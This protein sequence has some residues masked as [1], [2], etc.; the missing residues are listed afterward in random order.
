MSLDTTNRRTEAERLLLHHWKH[1]QFRTGQWEIIEAI[2][3]GEDVL[4]ILPT[5]GGKSI[6]YQLPALLQEGLTL[7]V[8]PLI[9][10]MQDQVAGLRARKISAA[11]IN[12]TLSA[13]EVDQRWTDAEFGRYRL[14]YV[15]PERLQSEVFQARA[16]R[17]PVKQIVVDEAHCISEWGR[18]FRPAY[19]EIAGVRALL[20]GPPVAAFTATAT[21]LVR[22]DIVEQLAL[23]APV[24]VA[25]GFD[26]PNITWSIFRTPSKQQKVLEIIGNVRGSGILYTATRKSAERWAYWLASQGETVEVYHGGLGT[27]T[28]AGVQDAWLKGEK[29]IIV[30]TNA[31]GMGIDKPDVRFVIH[32]EMPGSVEAYYQEAG[33]AGRDGKK[34]YAVLLFQHEDTRT[35]RYLLE[36]GHPDAR[37]VRIVYDAACNVAQI[38]IGTLPTSPVTIRYEVLQKVTGFTRGKLVQAVEILSR[39]KTWQVLPSKKYIGLLRFDQPVDGIRAYVERSGNRALGRF[40]NDLLRVVHA[41]AFSGWW[42]FDLRLFQRRTGIDRVRLAR[43][44]EFLAS[45]DLL[46]WQPPGTAFRVVLTH[47]RAQRLPVDDHMVQKSFR[48]AEIHF[49]DMLRYARSVTCRRQF[50]LAYFG[51]NHPSTCGTCDVCLGRHRD[52]SIQPEDEPLLRNILQQIE[53]GASGREWM[54]LEGIP[55]DRIDYLVAYLFQEAYISVR[56]PLEEA[57]VLEEKGRGWLSG[58]AP[59]DR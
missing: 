9:S 24:V 5:G 33:R 11:F 4:A 1:A 15:S 53:G 37:S 13:R 50:L 25:T 19:Q 17:L 21:P 49:Q 27:E 26:R 40:V 18:H 39:Q 41:D 31:F 16:S 46:S 10:L 58:W 2:L 51:E 3:D 6:C 12:S 29:R 35:Q 59:S 14:L 54:G 20:G 44:L 48:R 32:V 28:R 52:I 45:R 47:A 8:S 57:F 36:S 43:G 56:H 23:R 34:A 30:A 42:E 7:V 55:D 38:P 22:R